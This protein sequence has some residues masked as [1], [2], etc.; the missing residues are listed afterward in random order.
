M[1]ELVR[2][3][4]VRLSE[5][6]YERLKRICDKTGL[7]ASEIIRSSLDGVHLR[8]RPP[9]DLGA[10]YTE[11]NRIGNNINQ[12][13]RKANSKRFFF[14]NFNSIIE[15]QRK[16]YDAILNLTGDD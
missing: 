6:Q 5:R 16:I 15:G 3:V 10:L 1:L 14:G 9:A 8:E 4:P 7:S 11:I 12:I 13:A 2:V